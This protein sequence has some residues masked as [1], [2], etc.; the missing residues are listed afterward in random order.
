MYQLYVVSVD[1]R[2]ELLAYLGTKG[3]E[4]KVHYPIPLHLQEAA[5]GLGYQKGDFPVCEALAKEIITIPAHQHVSADQID[6][7]LEAFHAFAS[8]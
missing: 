4:C 6:Y 1:R 3:I 7:V 8:R 2:D 5:G